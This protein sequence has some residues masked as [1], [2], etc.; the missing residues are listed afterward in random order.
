MKNFALRKIFLILIEKIARLEL[1]YE[2]KILAD[3]KINIEFLRSCQKIL[4]RIKV[5]ILNNKE[6]LLDSY[7][8]EALSQDKIEKAFLSLEKCVA[9]FLEL[10]SLLSYLPSNN[11]IPEVQIFLTETLGI[12]RNLPGIASRVILL[13]PDFLTRNIHKNFSDLLF[14]SESENDPIAL[15]LPVM[16]NT[17]PLYWSILIKKVFSNIHKLKSDLNKIIDNLIRDENS[18]SW[19]QKAVLEKIAYELISDLFSIKLLGPAYYYLML[20]LGVFRSIAEAEHR[21]MP[22]LATRE[23]ILYQQLKKLNLANEIE[24]THN[25][26][27]N[28]SELSSKLKDILGFNVDLPDSENF[29]ENLVSNLLQEVNRILDESDLFL[30]N[31]F[32][33]SLTATERLLDGIM[34]SSSYIYNLD[35]IEKNYKKSYD[36]SSFNIYEYLNKLKEIPNTPQQIINAGW[37]YKEKTIDKVFQELLTSNNSHANFGL[38]GNYMRELDNILIKSIETLTIHKILLNEE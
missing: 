12:Q 6:I 28:L 19:E 21:Y 17:D 5:E 34:I 11:I 22:T 27:T 24:N 8:K 13:T 35:E 23:K 25:W 4:G 32:H 7:K 37:I 1:L 38:I 2:E 18:I 3:K 26:F 33:R 15:Y 9:G 31:D 10:H 36:E 30:Q 16:D 14:A 29:L 20:E